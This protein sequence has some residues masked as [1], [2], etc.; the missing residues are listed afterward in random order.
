M[1]LSVRS[2]GQLNSYRT[3]KY[4]FRDK[5][6][7]GTSSLMRLLY[8]NK[9]VLEISLMCLSQ[10]IVFWRFFTK[11][12][13]GTAA[14]ALH[15]ISNCVILVKVYTFDLERFTT[16]WSGRCIESPICQKLNKMRFFP[17]KNELFDFCMSQ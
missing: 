3:Q 6:L 12:K 2:L 13:N 9:L 1:H 16:I 17:Q 10:L 14:Y 7:G 15:D 8:L 4:N 5:F 11:G